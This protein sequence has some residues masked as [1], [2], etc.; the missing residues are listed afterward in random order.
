MMKTPYAVVTEKGKIVTVNAA[1]KNAV[2][3]KSTAF[4]ADITEIT[5]IPMS[6]ITGDAEVE[7]D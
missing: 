5:G 4:G 1:M 2:G 7:I 3:A 6:N